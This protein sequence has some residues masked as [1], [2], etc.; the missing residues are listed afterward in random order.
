MC[1]NEIEQKLLKHNGSNPIL[2]KLLSSDEIKIANKLLKQGKMQ[3]GISDDRSGLV[4][5]MNY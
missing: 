2:R 1:V 3:K 5:Y 4:I